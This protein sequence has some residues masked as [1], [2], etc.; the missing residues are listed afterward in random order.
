MKTIGLIGGMSWESSMD[1]YR[2]I[3][4]Y[5]KEIVGETHSCQS[6]MYSFDFDTV[7]KLQRKGDWAALTVE[8]VKQAE[9]LKNAGADFIVICANTMHMMAEAIEKQC[10]IKVLHI[11]DATS[12]EIVKR[13]LKT[14][15]LLGTNFTMTGDFYKNVFINNYNINII[16]P[17]EEDR[18]TVH[19]IIYKELILG[20]VNKESKQQYQKI[21]AKLIENGAEGV[22]LGCTEIPA[23]IKEGDVPIPVFDTTSIH[24]KAAVEYANEE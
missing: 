11:G 16:I 20:K 8:M 23:L 12:K 9:K 15:A 10:N 13:G 18:E 19:N 7:E 5:T 22:V 21:I 6:I 14:V 1:Y 24:A 4:E 3:N 2:L 17:N